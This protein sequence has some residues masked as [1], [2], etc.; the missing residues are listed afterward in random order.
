MQRAVKTELSLNLL[1]EPHDV[2]D[3]CAVALCHLLT[4]KQ[5]AVLEGL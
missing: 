2:A 1:P 3:A 5:R 4:S